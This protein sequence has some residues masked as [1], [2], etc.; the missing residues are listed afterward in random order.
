MGAAFWDTQQAVS[1]EKLGATALKHFAS[2]SS[3]ETRQ[4]IELLALNELLQVSWA[5]VIGGMHA[6]SPTQI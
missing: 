6:L 5:L 2:L 1:T 4:A 3:E